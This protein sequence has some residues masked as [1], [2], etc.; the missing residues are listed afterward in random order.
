MLL[1][2]L[3]LAGALGT[4]AAA[5]SEGGFSAFISA[6]GKRSMQAK[7]VAIDGDK[8]TFV[9]SDGSQFEAKPELFAEENKNSLHQ[10]LA[11][12]KQDRHRQLLDRV[13]SS[14]K[15]RVL[16]V[17]NSYSFDIPKVF[18]SL[19]KSEGRKV[20]VE[21]VTEGGCTLQKHAASTALR[22]KI[23]QGEWDIVVLQ[24]QSLVP[25]ILEGQRHQM[26]DGAAKSLVELVRESGAI[27]VFFL[28]WGR[29]DGDKINKAAF[30]DDTFEDMHLRLKKG[31][32]K[33]S[34]YAGHVHIVPV[35]EVWSNL[36]SA[37]KDE[38]FY[39]ADGSHPAEA[40]RYLAACVFYSAL[41]NVEV[42]KPE[43][44]FKHGADYAKFAKFALWQILP[45][46]IAGSE[47]ETEPSGQPSVQK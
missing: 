18:E 38:G 3:W 27:P 39:T 5:G 1:G 36:R 28:T 29:R 8:I 40:G 11:A 23:S 37:G 26:M 33:A 15:L 47:P 13:Q 25:A 19:A 35:G 12:M 2:L 20:H 24:E 22:Q 17:G 32:A 7:P 4:V 44:S 9:K 21:Q 10:W 34:A 43:R 46:P 41:Y 14:E 45:Y 31:Y 42:K 16:F 6:D 30:P